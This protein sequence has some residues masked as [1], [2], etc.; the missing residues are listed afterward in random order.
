MKLRG[1]YLVTP[2]EVDTNRLLDQVE[3]LLATRPALIQYRNKLADGALRRTQA[4]ALLARQLAV[5]ADS[6]LGRD[7]RRAQLLAV[8]AYRTEANPDTLAITENETKGGN[9]LTGAGLTWALGTVIQQPVLTSLP[10]IWAAGFQMLAAAFTDTCCPTM[11]RA[12]VINGSPR[13]VKAA[14]PIWGIKRRITRSFFT[15]C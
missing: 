5:T 4:T 12:R 1:L 11:E 15:R 8:Q 13:E 7:L 3:P 9:V 2:D 6:L 10:P 14:L